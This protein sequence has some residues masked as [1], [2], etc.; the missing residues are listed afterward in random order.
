MADTIT[1]MGVDNFFPRNTDKVP[2]SGI[3][4]PYVGNAVRIVQEKYTGAGLYAVDGNT[5]DSAPT[6]D[7]RAIAKFRWVRH[8]VRRAAW[9]VD[10]NCVSAI[11]QGNKGTIF[12][13]SKDL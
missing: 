11:F 12:I 9:R 7:P 5:H 8:Y 4:L 13:I 10:S 2:P 6:E 1:G 3:P